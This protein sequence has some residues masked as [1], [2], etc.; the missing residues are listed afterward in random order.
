MQPES[1]RP[2]AAA[3]RRPS[4][5]SLQPSPGLPRAQAGD[6][7]SALLRRLFFA[8][9]GSLLLSSLSERARGCGPGHKGG[10][11]RDLSAAE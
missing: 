9:T 6:L 5:T 10:L 11:G 1:G 8:R 4:P 3:E 2:G 7:A